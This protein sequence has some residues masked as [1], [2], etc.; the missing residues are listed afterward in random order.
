MMKERKLAICA[1]LISLTSWGSPALAANDLASLDWSV[2]S[3]HPLD[4]ESL[5]PEDIDALISKA[6]DAYWS[7]KICSYKFVDPARD[8]TFRLIAAFDGSGYHTCNRI[9]VVGKKGSRFTVVNDWQT[10]MAEKVDNI[11]RDLDDDGHTEL[12]IPEAWSKYEIGHCMAMW[13]K[14][15]K[16]DGD[17]FANHSREYP[18]LY[19]ARQKELMEE[20]PRL[21]EPTCDQMEL[22]KIARFFG[23]AATAG[24]AEASM[25][26]LAP[27][28][29]MRRKAAAVFADIGDDVSKKNLDSLSKDADPLT[30][31]TARLYLE[32]PPH[33]DKE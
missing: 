12:I 25:W 15:Y 26:M 7:I 3:V 24:Y 5:A 27:E 14:A 16:W 13:Q 30:A 9:V 11:L 10:R 17:H 1:A 31:E 4:K 8:G 18:Q 22:D 23:T 2:N 6:L 21:R 29:F 19:K 33:P 20:I 32:T 28:P